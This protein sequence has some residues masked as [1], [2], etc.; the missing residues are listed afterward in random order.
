MSVHWKFERS[1]WAP[2]WQI[3]YAK[4]VHHQNET[5]PIWTHAE[6]QFNL[7]VYSGSTL[8]NWTVYVSAQS[9]A[10][11]KDCI[12]LIGTASF[13]GLKQIFLI[14]S[15]LITFDCNKILLCSPIPL[16]RVMSHRFHG[17]RFWFTHSKAWWSCYLHAAFLLW[18]CWWWAN[19]K[20]HETRI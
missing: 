20:D 6:T 11:K 12:L 3:I 17:D 18:R 7:W 14:Y 5:E 13:L 10:N 9:R 2:K 8:G 15:L 1:V 4:T 16:G 19:R